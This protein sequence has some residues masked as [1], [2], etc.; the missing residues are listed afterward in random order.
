MENFDYFIAKQAREFFREYDDRYDVLELLQNEPKPLIEWPTETFYRFASEGSENFVD[1]WGKV[2]KNISPEILAKY[3]RGDA[4]EMVRD[5][6][7]TN[8]AEDC[9]EVSH[10]IF[11]AEKD[12]KEHILDNVPSLSENS[13]DERIIEFNGDIEEYIKNKVSFQE[14]FESGIYNLKITDQEKVPEF[15]NEVYKDVLNRTAPNAYI[16]IPSKEDISIKFTDQNHAIIKTADGAQM[17]PERTASVFK[18]I[19]NMLSENQNDNIEI[20][21]TNNDNQIT[22]TEDKENAKIYCEEFQDISIK[23]IHKVQ[24]MLNKDVLAYKKGIK[25]DIV[26]KATKNS[27]GNLKS[28]NRKGKIETEMKSQRSQ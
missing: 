2:S 3:D 1:A 13:F 14:L 19:R 7:L 21:Y 24:S 18:I 6:E 5:F 15:L 9:N 11:Q 16:T 28:V 4:M 22:I 23:D 12:I 25:N 26:Y 10:V 20:K 17:S 27:K 8:Y